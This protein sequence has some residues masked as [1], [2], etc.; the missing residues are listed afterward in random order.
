MH[1]TY[2]SYEELLDAIE[3]G[4][5]VSCDDYVVVEGVPVQIRPTIRSH[6]LPGKGNWRNKSNWVPKKPWLTFHTVQW[7]DGSTTGNAFFEVFSDFPSTFIRGEGATVEEAEVMAWNK[8]VRASRC[9][10]HE[11]ERR[12]YKNGV[13]FCKHCGM[14]KSE[15][16][17]PSEKCEICGVATYH[18]IDTDG[19]VYCETHVDMIPDEKASSSLLWLRRERESPTLDKLTSDDIRKGIEGLAKMVNNVR[20]AR[21]KKAK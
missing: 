5:E 1:K 10:E 21:K 6:C 2:T 7:G 15:A 4:D 14:L 13:G 8:L 16:F 20:H 11:F 17:E 9:P 12:G 19:K 3:N 18:S